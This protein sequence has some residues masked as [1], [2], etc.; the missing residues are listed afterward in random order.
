[1]G[2]A[3]GAATS[4]YAATSPDL[5]DRGGVYLEDCGIAEIVEEDSMDG[6]R[7]Y[8]LDEDGAARL[9]TLSEEVVGERFSPGT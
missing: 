9:W 5:A 2:I 8:A 3:A 6:V 7:A 4:C 1:M